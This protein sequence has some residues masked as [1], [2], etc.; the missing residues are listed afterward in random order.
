MTEIYAL[1]ENGVIARISSNPFEGAIKVAT[2]DDDVF[3]F[4]QFFTVDSRGFAV[5]DPQYRKL[6]RNEFV[7]SRGPNGILQ[8]YRTE[9][10]HVGTETVEVTQE[11]A[12]DVFSNLNDYYEYSGGVLSVNPIRKENFLKAQR[13]AELKRLL[14]ESDYKV[15]KNQELASAGLQPEYQPSDLHVQRQALRNEINLLQS[16]IS[17]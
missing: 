7:I 1:V 17:Q 16:Q 10:E 3:R 6:S 12:L 5:L 14:A 11:Q 9:I 4:H 13:I 8:L 2:T 15:I